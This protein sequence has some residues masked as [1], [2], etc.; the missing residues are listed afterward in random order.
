MHRLAI[1]TVEVEGAV[2]AVLAV[3]A[4]LGRWQVAG[5]STEPRELRKYGKQAGFVSARADSYLHA[6][7]SYLRTAPFEERN[8]KGKTG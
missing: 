3:L 2:L 6:I 8:E 7:T 5:G 4:L 1:D